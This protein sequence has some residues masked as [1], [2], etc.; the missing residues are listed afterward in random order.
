MKK[1]GY[2]YTNL[3]KQIFI[4]ICFLYLLLRFL[5]VLEILVFKLDGYYENMN[6]PLTLLLYFV[7]F[8]VLLVVLRGHKICISAYDE[9]T[10][11]YYNTLLRKSKSLDL[12]TVKMAVFDTFGVKFYDHQDADYKN[13]KPMFFLPFFRDGII[14]ALDIDAFFK[15][16]KAK[17][18]VQVIKTF[19]VLP[20]YTKK[21]TALTVFYGF[22]AVFAFMNTAT[23][24]DRRHRSVPKPLKLLT[25]TQIPEATP[26]SLM[27]AASGI[28][29]CKQRI[30]LLQLIIARSPLCFRLCACLCSLCCSCR[31]G[32]LACLKALLLLILQIL[33]HALIMIF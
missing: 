8:L 33:D 29:F 22:L 30:R 4:G 28:F 26:T 21:W 23:P 7:I 1:I 18:G 31:L 19:K 32:R 24:A 16:M 3:A 25:Q 13:E 15:M 27:A 10:L 11:T 14:E 20:G 12:S 5:I 6:F 9:Q 2:H 17:E